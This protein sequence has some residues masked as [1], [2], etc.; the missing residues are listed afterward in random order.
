[1]VDEELVYPRF[2][3][4]DPLMVIPVRDVYPDGINVIVDI[5][6]IPSILSTKV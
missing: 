6:C 1:M 4:Y 3:G 5:Y 2:I